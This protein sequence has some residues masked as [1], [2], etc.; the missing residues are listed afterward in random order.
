MIGE[1][2]AGPV[3]DQFCRDG[4]FAVVE[5]RYM[6]NDTAMD[7]DPI[8]HSHENVRRACTELS[9]DYARC[10]DFRDYDALLTLFREDAV[11]EVGQP[12]RG[13]AAIRAYVRARPDEIRSRHVISN[14]FVDPL[15]GGEARGICYLTLYSHRGPESLSPA[16]APLPGPLL[17]GHYEDRFCCRGGRWQFQSRR[18]QVAFHA[19]THHRDAPDRPAAADPGPDHLL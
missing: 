17:I 11:L 4:E 18:L 13:A 7:R 5:M 9:L 19:H 3:P 15:G 12:L 14:V 8:E 6:R 1:A 2:G 10:V 16:P